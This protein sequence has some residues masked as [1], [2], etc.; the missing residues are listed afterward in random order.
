MDRAA[1]RTAV[2]G[3]LVSLI[4][5]CCSSCIDR[6]RTTAAS[7]ARPPFTIRVI[8]P[9]F[10]ASPALHPR[11]FTAEY[12]GNYALDSVHAGNAYV[13]GLTGV[14]VTVA[15]I[16]SGVADIAKL[17]GEIAAHIN[18]TA[19]PL[20]EDDHGT[21]VA[22]VI[23]AK[24]DGVYMHGIAY[25]SRIADIKAGS[26]LSF[27]QSD[28]RTALEVA[29]GTNQSF[30]TVDAAIV[31]LS[32]GGTA[33]ISNE[34][35]T[36]LDA[37]IDAGKVIVIAA[38]NNTGPAVAGGNPSALAL[39]AADPDA[40]GQVIIAGASTQA[41]TL[42][43]FSHRAGSGKSFYLVAPGDQIATLDS[44]GAPITVSG[45]SYS[46]PIISGA[47]ALL[48][49]EFP[50]LTAAKVVQI[51]LVT[52][53]PLATGSS[54]DFGAG[55]LN[56]AKAIQPIG[57]LSIPTSEIAGGNASLLSNARL[58]LG[59]PF[60]SGARTALAG[61]HVLA[62]DS[63]QR[64]YMAALPSPASAPRDRTG[65][66]SEWINPASVVA[67]APS[68]LRLAAE[69][70]TGLRPVGFAIIPGNA[71][72]PN[73]M[74]IAVSLSADTVA[75]FGQHL[76]ALN[77]STASLPDMLGA[78]E[79][80]APL[81]LRGDLTVLPQAG[82]ANDGYGA[83]LSHRFGR[84]QITAAAISSQSDIG[85][86]GVLYRNGATGLVQL[87][88]AA[89]IA[90]IDLG[91]G[92]GHLTEQGGMFG[93]IS[94]GALSVGSESVS[95]FLTVMAAGHPTEH[96]ELTAAFTK[97]QTRARP[98]GGL[99][100][101]VGRI[102]SDAFAIGAI[103][104][105]GIVKGDMLGFQIAQ[106][107][108]VSD[109]RADLLLPVAMDANGTILRSTRHV[110]LAPKGRE[111]DLQLAYRAPLETFAGRGEPATVQ[112]F[113][114]ARLNP[115]HDTNAP[116]DYAAGIRYNIVF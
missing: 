97:G 99:F 36:D 79:R 19:N 3:S 93:S 29:A 16:D 77:L 64:G 11:I 22:A 53:D 96:L 37:A 91:L 108:R 83:A 10:P 86:A 107:I 92:I 61:L 8:P 89:T 90:A 9:P 25:G 28:L 72:K 46:A 7:F 111:I 41:G 55:L 49:Q 52:A 45:T 73:G 70:S 75:E 105:D 15:V 115:G 58:T 103:Q 102:A 21:S 18:V 71:T 65:A 95:T 38:G 42:A 57:A 31:N 67:L 20:I 14:G 69:G 104:H 94:S 106:P 54:A 35:R 44:K 110:N 32:L 59:Q 66:G 24:S 43:G 39:F 50:N 1:Y 80:G 84:F 81:F 116:T 101:N 78:D 100:S 5:A 26:E 85:D 33:P 2:S 76:S 62:L 113:I 47:A 23:A 68:Q 30:G 51:L 109:A 114:M 34:L 87:T 48:K 88:T 12:F 17:Q 27:S 56:L 112:A 4:L 6:D 82:F 60:G 40:K 63:Y 13:A 98:G 74:D